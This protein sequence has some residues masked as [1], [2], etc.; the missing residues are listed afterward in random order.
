MPASLVGGSSTSTTSKW[1]AISTP[2]SAGFILPCIERFTPRYEHDCV[3]TM[4]PINLAVCECAC[5]DIPRYTS[6]IPMRCADGCDPKRSFGR[7]ERVSWLQRCA[8]A[9]PQSARHVQDASR[10]VRGG[11]MDE[12]GPDRGCPPPQL[13]CS[14]SCSRMQTRVERILRSH[15]AMPSRVQGGCTSVISEACSAM[16]RPCVHLWVP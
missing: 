2:R 15:P 16:L 11:E 6:D 13:A 10:R 9:V 12:G 14:V 3:T 4:T 1:V 5:D 8:T 7:R